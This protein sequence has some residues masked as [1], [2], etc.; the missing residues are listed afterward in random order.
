MVSSSLGVLVVLLATSPLWIIL[1]HAV[2]CRLWPKGP[3]QVVAATAGLAGAA[4]TGLLACTLT[5]V[6]PGSISD[7][8]V[9]AIY[10]ATVYGCVAYSYFHLFNLSETAR[11][12]RILSELYHAGP[13]TAGQIGRLYDATSLLEMR[14]E[15][16]LATRQIEQRADRFVSTG[17]TLYLVACLVRAWRRVLGFRAVGP[18]EPA[19]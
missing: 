11:R 1:T 15:R 2:L 16:L 12:I 10:A 6:C 9:E 17:R 5:S 7:H 18:R 8:P 4:P 19:A 3:A 13:L 14:F